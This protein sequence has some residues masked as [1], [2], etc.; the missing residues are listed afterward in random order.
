MMHSLVATLW[1]A[2]FSPDLSSGFLRSTDLTVAQLPTFVAQQNAE[3]KLPDQLKHRVVEQE[4]L[5][6]ERFSQ[7]NRIPVSDRTQIRSL[8]EQQS[9]PQVNGATELQLR[10]RVLEQ[11]LLRSN[12]A[13]QKQP[14]LQPT[15]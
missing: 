8:Q 14:Q 5:R 1:L 15:R 7:Q 12:W 9:T 6:L 2:G 4:V 11:E 10:E 13:T 3:K